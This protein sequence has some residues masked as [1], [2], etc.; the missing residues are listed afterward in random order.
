MSEIYRFRPED[1][2]NVETLYRRMYGSDA[3][4]ARQLRWDWQHAR[5]PSNL[6]GKPVIWVVREGPTIIGHCQALSVRVSLK[7]LEVGGAWGPDVIVVPER[8]A[9]GLNESLVRTWDRYTGIAL[10][11]RRQSDLGNVLDQLR[12]PQSHLLPCMVKPLTRRAV[13]LPQWSPTLNRVIS[14]LS[15]PIVRI[16][17]RSRPLRAECQPIRK[18]DESF[19]NLWERLAP[20]FELAVRRDAAYLNWRYVEPPHIRHS[21]VALKREGQLH[22]YAVYRHRREPLGKVTV[23]VD[24]LVA[25]ED[26]SGL[27]TLLRW[28]DREARA[29]DSDKIRC[30]TIHSGFRKILRR[31]GY[32]PVKSSLNVAIKINAVQVPLGFYEDPDGWHFTSGDSDLGLLT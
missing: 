25:P 18:F 4:D 22:G 28:I 30:H 21:A 23:L 6:D 7:G 11:V 15:F 26:I 3:A 13:R 29:E 10:T 1:R 16:A 20:K 9:Q 32:F 2:R 8:D 12:W 14:A 17:S 24:F 27:K 31:N 19:T 5:N